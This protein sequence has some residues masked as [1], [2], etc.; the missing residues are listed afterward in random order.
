[1]AGLLSY[2]MDNTQS[3]SLEEGIEIYLKWKS[4]SIKSANSRYRIR[5]ENLLDFVGGGK[6]LKMLSHEDIID[7]QNSM[8]RADYAEAT[9][10]FSSRII[11]NFVT[12]WNGRGLVNI[13]PSEIKEAKF[14]TPEQPVVDLEDF[15]QMSNILDESY[16]EELQRKLAIHLLWDTG[17]RVSEMTDMCL[18]NLKMGKRGYSTATIRTKK[19]DRYNVV[20]WGNETMEL[21][22]K[23]LG[24]RL[25]QNHPSDNLFVRTDKKS[26]K[27]LTTKTIERWVKQL[28][29]EAMIGKPITPHSFRHGKAHH[30]LNSGGTAIDVQTVLRHKN[31]NSS[32][33]YMRLNESKYIERA[34]RF[35]NQ[36]KEKV[37]DLFQEGFKSELAYPTGMVYNAK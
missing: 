17:M 35:L 5:L 2:Y 8:K 28:S 20:M 29:I 22:N 4:A 11:R 19:T 33:N 36:T 9:I 6:S 13:N 31:L 3:L 23:Y 12:F 26:N 14:L 16:I 1:M 7:F 10:A 30:I 18:S 24:W 37:E 15:Q 21:L 27:G 34:G 32:L 25:A